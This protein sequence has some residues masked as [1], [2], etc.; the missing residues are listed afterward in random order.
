VFVPTF[1]DDAMEQFAIVEAMEAGDVEPTRVV[2][3]ALDVLA[4]IIV[5]IVAS[6]PEWTA[7]GL[8][9]F[10]R[11]AYPYHAL[12]RA[13][14][15]ETLAMLAGKYPSDIAAELEA[16]ISWDR[17]T[18]MLTPARASRMVATISGGTIPDRGLYTVNLADKTRLGELDEEFVHES[19]VAMHSS[20]AAR[21]GAFARSNMIVWWWCPAPGAPARMPFWHGEFMARSN[22]LTKRV[23]E[24]AS[25]AR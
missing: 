3:N 15:D 1:R 25:H 8:Y 11:R 4:Q 7:T 2:Q 18:D 17:V 6:E 20:S 12:T 22:H 16:R 14:F 23:G 19:R 24:S 13:A 5:A 9:D 21:R 10:A